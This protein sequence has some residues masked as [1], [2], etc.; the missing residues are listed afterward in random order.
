MFSAG[1]G[2]R[3]TSLENR[4]RQVTN[5]LFP[6]DFVGPRAGLKCEMKHSVAATTTMVF[7]VFKR[8]DLWSMF[9]AHPGQAY[10]LTWIAAVEGHF[11]GET[12]ATLG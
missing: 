8:D 3:Y 6:D 5:F 9:R 1:W 10:D 11:L 7:C 12:I 2:T 4:R